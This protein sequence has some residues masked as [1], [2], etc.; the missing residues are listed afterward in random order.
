MG[1]HGIQA[2]MA[3][4]VT[5]V[6]IALMLGMMYWESEPGALPLALILGGGIWWFIA[7]RRSRA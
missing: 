4:T 7:R 2:W 3:A 5:A 1:R 6:G